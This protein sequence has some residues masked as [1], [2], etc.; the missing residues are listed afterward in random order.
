L[1]S[2]RSKPQA[3]GPPLFGCLRLLT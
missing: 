1:L 2:T 3:G